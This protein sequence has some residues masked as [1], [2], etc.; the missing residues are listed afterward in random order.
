MLSLTKKGKVGK[1]ELSGFLDAILIDHFD[2]SQKAEKRYSLTGFEIGRPE[3]QNVQRLKPGHMI[4]DNH[5][6][7]NLIFGDTFS[8]FFYWDIVLRVPLTKFVVI[9]I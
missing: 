4:N 9:D 5:I 1:F 7:Q 6:R 8:L 3:I 2:L